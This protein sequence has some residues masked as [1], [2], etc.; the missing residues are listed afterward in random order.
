MIFKAVLTAQHDFMR[1]DVLLTA[2]QVIRFLKTSQIS[3]DRKNDIA[4]PHANTFCRT[5]LKTFF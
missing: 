5:D 2:Q 3:E 4:E 1:F